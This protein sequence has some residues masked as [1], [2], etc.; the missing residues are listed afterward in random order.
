MLTKKEFSKRKFLTVK[1]RICVIL[2]YFMDH[3]VMKDIIP[4]SAL[5]SYGS[6]KC[7]KYNNIQALLLHLAQ[8]TYIRLSEQ[9]NDLCLIGTNFSCNN[10]Y[11]LFLFHKAIGYA[12]GQSDLHFRD[13]KNNMF[14]HRF[15]LLS[16]KTNK[17]SQSC[18][19]LL[20]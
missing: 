8:I 19:Y 15:P 13:I 3:F 10:D 2:K 18:G 20:Y 12:A 1:A 9:I 7:S 11:F 4:S 14:Q 6:S 17:K 16:V 5:S